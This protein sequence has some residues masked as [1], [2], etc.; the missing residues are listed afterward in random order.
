MEILFHALMENG[1]HVLIMA[2]RFAHHF[3]NESVIMPY[4]LI[5][6][7]VTTKDLFASQSLMTFPMNT[8]TYL[9]SA[10]ISP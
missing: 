9:E 1:Q 3:L 4:V 5:L 10:R 7:H 2:I 6:I 8:M